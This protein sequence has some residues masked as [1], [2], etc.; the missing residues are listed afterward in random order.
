[1]QTF[2]LTV[3]ID[4]KRDK[5]YDHLSEP[6]NMI[7]LQP[8][9]TEIDI[10]KK[11]KDEGGIALRPFNTVETFRWLGIPIMRDKVYSVIH[12]TKPKDELELHVYK[13][14]KIEI[15]FRYKFRQFN[16][17]RTQVTQ[18][19]QFVRMNKMLA[20]FAENQAKHTQRT[21]LSNLKVR[22]EKH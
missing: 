6:I 12:L 2:E 19:V 20:F 7:G 5:V 8:R 11:K 15:V 13:R 14:P 16:D 10:L 18:T 17:G 22:L 4:C 21:L 1:M 3:F 9:L